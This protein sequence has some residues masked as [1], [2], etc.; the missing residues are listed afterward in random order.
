MTYVHDTFI[1]RVF[2]EGV[3]SR[4]VYGE[5]ARSY[6]SEIQDF[7]NEVDK[8]N[9]DVP[10]R[11]AP[12]AVSYFPSGDDFTNITTNKTVFVLCLDKLK[13]Q[14]VQLGP[15]TILANH[16]HPEEQFGIANGEVYVSIDG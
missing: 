2:K 15:Y 14:L 3:L 9:D 10:L 12:S 7:M 6:C 8:L 4:K 11:S 13:I 5:C 16:S 1:V